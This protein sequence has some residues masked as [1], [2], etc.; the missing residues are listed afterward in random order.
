MHKKT[1]LIVHDASKLELLSKE[2]A[3]LVPKL[4]KE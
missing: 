2:E 3:A 1:E 4:K